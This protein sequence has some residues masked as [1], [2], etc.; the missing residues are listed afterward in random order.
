M[1]LGLGVLC[2]IIPNGLYAKAL[3]YVEAS[4]AGILSNIEP[5]TGVFLAF[6]LFKE[7]MEGLQWLGIGLVVLSLILVQYKNTNKIEGNTE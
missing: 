3:N 7:K 6:V 2:T 4:K 1:I 5:V